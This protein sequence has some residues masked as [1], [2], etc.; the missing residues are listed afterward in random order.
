MSEIKLAKLPDRTPAMLRAFLDGDR[1]FVRSQ[2][3][4]GRDG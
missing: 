4:R 2:A 1:A 3:S